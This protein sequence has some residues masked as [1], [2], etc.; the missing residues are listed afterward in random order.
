MEFTT[1]GEL[2]TVPRIYGNASGLANSAMSLNAD[3]FV[4]NSKCC[5]VETV[6][7]FEFHWWLSCQY[8]MISRNVATFCVDL[9]T[10]L[11]KSD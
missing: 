2:R 5:H 9:T 11:K 4:A 6:P 7:K 8:D 3:L 10:F 1:D